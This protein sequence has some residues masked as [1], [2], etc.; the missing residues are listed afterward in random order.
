MRG[1][2]IPPDEIEPQVSCV[3]GLGFALVRGI[4]VDPRRHEGTRIRLPMSAREGGPVARPKPLYNA[5]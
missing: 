3:F 1:S 5:P 4:W 2:T